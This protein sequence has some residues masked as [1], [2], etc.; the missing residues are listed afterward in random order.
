MYEIAKNLIQSQTFTSHLGIKI[1]RLD[2]DKA[3][4]MLPYKPFLGEER[5]NGGAIAS[6]VDLAATGAFW[7][8][9]DLSSKSK[10]ATVSLNINFMKLVRKSDIFAIA[11]VEKRGA[12]ICVGTVTV[13]SNSTEKVALATVTYK[14]N[15]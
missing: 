4:L 14:L 2:K 1:T 5:V 12:S 7:C 9:P 11:I 13:K 3:Q 8:Q 15:A 6:L 10:G